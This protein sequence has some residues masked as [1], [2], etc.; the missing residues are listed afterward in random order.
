M[1]GRRSGVTRHAL[2]G[3]GALGVGGAP[4]RGAPQT[5]GRRPP[6]PGHDRWTA[7]GAPLGRAIAEGATEA[8]FLETRGPA[9]K[10]PR[11]RR[12]WVNT[13]EPQQYI[14][15]SL[16]GQSEAVS[17]R[18]PADTLTAGAAAERSLIVSRPK[19]AR[20][21]TLA[22]LNPTGATEPDWGRLRTFVLTSMDECAPP[23]PPPYSEAPGSEFYRQAKAVYDTGST[24][25]PEQREIALYW[26]DNP[27]ESGTPPGHWLLIASQLVP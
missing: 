19:S 18:N 26:A 17:L 1:A 8:R 11:G 23:R 7:Y 16:S 21:K 2:A 15:S 27:G 24:L 22:A 4:R 10:P 12:Y 25:T 20:I 9:G 5:G 13:A 6:G 14:S 3:G